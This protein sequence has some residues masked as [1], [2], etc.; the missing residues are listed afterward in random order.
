MPRITFDAPIRCLVSARG[1]PFERD[2]FSRKFGSMDGIAGA[3]VDQPAAAQL[4]NPDG[5]AP[6]DALVLYDMPGL[7]FT[8]A[9]APPAF[10]DPP[11]DLPCSLRALFGAGKGGRCA[12]SRARRTADLGRVWRLARR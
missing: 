5:M 7:D 4:M 6:Y 10:V 1:H 11:K 12:P 9:K 8:S 3:M 2:E